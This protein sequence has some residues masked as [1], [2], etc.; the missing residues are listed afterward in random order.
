MEGSTI[1]NRS[2]VEWLDEYR[3]FSGVRQM[4]DAYNTG[5]GKS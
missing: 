4:R 1:L 2:P 3:A 5:D